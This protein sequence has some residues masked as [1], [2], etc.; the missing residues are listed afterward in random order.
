MPAPSQSYF[1]FS[2]R[3]LALSIGFLL[4]AYMIQRSF[5]RSQE[6]T[7]DPIV[8]LPP[9]PPLDEAET[10][11][12]VNTVPYG[13]SALLELLNNTM[14]V[15]SSW[16]GRVDSKEC[17]NFFSMIKSALELNAAKQDLAL[18]V[19][20]GLS[21]VC[22]PKDFLM[23]M[24]IGAGYNAKERVIYITPEQFTVDMLIHEVRHHLR[25]LRHSTPECN[26]SHRLAP[27]PIYLKVDEEDGELTED[28]Q[29]SVFNLEQGLNEGDNRIRNFKRQWILTKGGSELNKLRIKERKEFERYRTAAKTCL[30]ESRLHNTRNKYEISREDY[31]GFLSKGWGENNSLPTQG[32]R[33][34]DYMWV[35]I[36]SI[37]F[38]QG[39]IYA[40]FWVSNPEAWLIH[41]PDSVKKA[42]LG[43]YSNKLPIVKLLER[44]ELTLEAFSDEGMKAFYPR[45]TQILA[46]DERLCPLPDPVPYPSATIH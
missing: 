39:K 17:E 29:S 31:N 28:S 42:I 22:V 19:N 4:L 16:L 33:D 2:K 20:H 12:S 3:V 46:E 38:Q 6:L 10:S 40:T 11:V 8:D 13:P 23:K 45:V 25:L 5:Y 32:G 1:L 21:F 34:L 14:Q 27:F 26:M 7:T 43:T 15:H 37:E 41:L 44:T 9:P 36:T 35:E 30:R 24:G 18:T